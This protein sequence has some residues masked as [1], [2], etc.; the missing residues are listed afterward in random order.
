MPNLDCAVP[1][2]NCKPVSGSGLGT[3]Y[4]TPAFAGRIEGSNNAIN[5]GLD[6]AASAS[7]VPLV[8]IQ[9]V[10]HGFASGN[11]SNRYYKLATSIEPGVCCGLGFP[12]GLLSFDG[13][14][15][16]NT[17]YALTANEF[18]TTINKA[19]GTHI[20]E[21]DVKAVYKGTRCSN[22]KYCYPDPYAP[23]NDTP[24]A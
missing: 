16:S 9:T 24:P 4:I 23:P 20:P 18:I 3:Y 17:G 8:D 19:Y 7:H 21:I 22:P 14:H 6:A 5:Q 15:P 1:K 12:Y 2:P 10:F 11:P 13:L